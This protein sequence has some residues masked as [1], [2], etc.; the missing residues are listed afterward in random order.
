MCEI[1]VM[2]VT[3]N[4]E[5]FVNSNDPRTLCGLAVVSIFRHI[6]NVIR[7][8]TVRVGGRKLIPRLLA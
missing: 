7:A 6:T 8:Y 3:A 5:H 2:P 1:A 4:V